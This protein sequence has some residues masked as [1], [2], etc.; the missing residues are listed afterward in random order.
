MLNDD[1]RRIGT[2]PF[3]VD[4]LALDELFDFYNEQTIPYASDHIACLVSVCIAGC[5]GAFD[6]CEFA[7]AMEDALGLRRTQGI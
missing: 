1:H 2:A 4:T 3:G 6:A 7:R 5:R